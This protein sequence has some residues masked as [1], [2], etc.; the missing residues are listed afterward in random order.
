VID[1]NTPAEVPKQ[2]QANATLFRL[3]AS[4]SASAKILIGCV[5]E[6]CGVIAPRLLPRIGLILQALHDSQVLEEDHIIAWF[7]APPESSWLVN[8]DVATKV[9]AKAE[10]YVEWLKNADGTHFT[11]DTSTINCL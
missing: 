6:L 1:T 8:K 4:D 2:F 5:E 10:P 7:E 3:Y 11:T 9:R